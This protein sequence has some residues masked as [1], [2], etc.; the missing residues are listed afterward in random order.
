[1]AE[2]APKELHP[3]PEDGPV[4]GPRLHD[5]ADLADVTFQGAAWG[6]N[7]AVTDAMRAQLQKEL[8]AAR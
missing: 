6:G 1:M 7:G 4:G 3:Q 2:R 5:D 8:I